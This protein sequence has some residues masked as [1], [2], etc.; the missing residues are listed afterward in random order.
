MRNFDQLKNP[1]AVIASTTALMGGGL[2][3]ARTL[4]GAAAFGQQPTAAESTPS[5]ANT[6]QPPADTSIPYEGCWD[7]SSLTN[8]DE[9]DCQGKA[10]DAEGN[11]GVDLI[12][13]RHIKSKVGSKRITVT[14]G[15][16]RFELWFGNEWLYACTSITNNYVKLQLIEKTNNHSKD[17]LKSTRFIGNSS[18]ISGDK[19]TS[20]SPKFQQVTTKKQVFKLPHALTKSELTHHKYGVRDTIVSE[21]LIQVPYIDNSNPESSVPGPMLVRQSKPH[22]TWIK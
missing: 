20:F 7:E 4:D 12:A 17:G 5:T 8:L 3:L 6:C 19:S 22:T 13:S 15:I 10:V 14:E 16:R 18:T 9:N 2:A 11:G 1:M 21:P